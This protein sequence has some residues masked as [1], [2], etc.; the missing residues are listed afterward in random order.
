MEVCIY[1]NKPLYSKTRGRLLRFSGEKP[2]PN[3]GDEHLTEVLFYK[4]ILHSDEIIRESLTELKDKIAAYFEKEL[5][6]DLSNA[7]QVIGEWADANRVT[8]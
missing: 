1:K 5:Q 7:M 8:E 2:K 6:N 4:T 3:R